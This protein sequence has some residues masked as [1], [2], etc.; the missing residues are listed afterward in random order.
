MVLIIIFM[1]MTHNS[2][3]S[4][5]FNL[6]HPSVPIDK[7]NKCILDVRA[8]VIQNE[9]KINQLISN[10]ITVCWGCLVKNCITVER[11]L[12]EFKVYAPSKIF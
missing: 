1:L 11:L 10:M 9:I 8:W 2:T 4:I 12:A 6:S 7:I 3:I 5:S